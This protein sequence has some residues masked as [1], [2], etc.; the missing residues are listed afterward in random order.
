MTL[1][2]TWKGCPSKLLPQVVVAEIPTG[3][4]ER[5][6]MKMWHASRLLVVKTPMRFR[7]EIPP[8]QKLQ[9]GHG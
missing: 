6:W 4:L 5:V 1:Q 3:I 9:K 7:T 8:K 2:S